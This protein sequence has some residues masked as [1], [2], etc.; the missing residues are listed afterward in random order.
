M[1]KER[2]C[3]DDGRCWHSCGEGSC[4]RVNNCAPFTGVYPD[5]PDEDWPDDVK[6]ANPPENGTPCIEDAIVRG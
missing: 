1:C 5:E 6:A 2:R 4:W 3:P